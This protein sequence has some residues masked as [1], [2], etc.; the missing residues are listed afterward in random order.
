MI[1]EYKRLLNSREFKG[2]KSKNKDSFL[3]SFVLIDNPQ[4]DFYNKNDTMTS[5]L[6]RDEIE[7]KDNEEFLKSHDKLKE[8]KLDEVKVGLREAL[9]FVKDIKNYSRK[10][11]IL[12]DTKHPFW[13]ITLVSSSRL[14]NI[15]IDA[16]TKKVLSM[17]EEPISKFMKKVV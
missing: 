13:N 4:F 2:W 17:Q 3:C 7:I 11:I 6:M 10:I 9:D 1:E 14:F 8:L 16:V 12:Q 15:K 5:F